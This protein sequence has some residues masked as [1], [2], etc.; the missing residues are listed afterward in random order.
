MKHDRIVLFLVSLLLLS[1]VIYSVRGNTKEGY[2]TF[3]KLDIKWK[4]RVNV[5]GI[6]TKWILVLKYSDG[7]EII[8]VEDSTPKNLKDFNDVSIELLKNTDVDKKIFTGTNKLYV[9][10]NERSE[11]NLAT[12]IDLQFKESDFSVNVTS[13]SNTNTPIGDSIEIPTKFI[14]VDCIGSWSDWGDCSKPC[15]GGFQTRKYTVETEKEGNGKSC[16]EVDGQLDNKMCNTQVCP[17]PPPP[18]APA[19]T[20]QD[21]VGEWVDS[22]CDSFC[23]AGKKQRRYQHVIGQALG[24]NACPYS[25]GYIDPTLYDCTST[26]ACGTSNWNPNY[27]VPDSWFG[28]ECPPGT[29][30][31][32]EKPNDCKG[33]WADWSPCTR[34]C[35][36]GTKQRIYKVIS[37]SY[38]GGKPCSQPMYSTEGEKCNT[39][40]CVARTFPELPSAP[41]SVNCDDPVIGESDA[42]KDVPGKDC[43]GEWVHST[44]C[45][46]QCG[47]GLQTLKYQVNKESLR[48]G[49]CENKGKT[50]EVDCQLRNNCFFQN[51][52]PMTLPPTFNNVSVKSLSCPMQTHMPDS[53]KNTC[54]KVEQLDPDTS[55]KIPMCNQTK[56]I[57]ISEIDGLDLNT[58]NSLY[59]HM[60]TGN[61]T[62]DSYFYEKR[63]KMC[64][65][66]PRIQWT[67]FTLDD[68]LKKCSLQDDCS[69]AD[70]FSE[71]NKDTPNYQQIPGD[72]DPDDDRRSYRTYHGLPENGVS[73]LRNTC[74]LHGENALA[75]N[76]R[77]NDDDP[78]KCK[79]NV[80]TSKT[81]NWDHFIRRKKSDHSSSV[82]SKIVLAEP[83]STSSSSSSSSSSNKQSVEPDIDCVGKWKIPS[84]NAVWNDGDK[85]TSTVQYK[86]TTPKSGNG[87]DCKSNMLTN[88][89]I[90]KWNE[91]IVKDGD[92]AEFLYPRAMNTKEKVMGIVN[93]DTPGYDV[94]YCI[95]EKNTTGFA[96]KVTINGQTQW[97]CNSDTL[98]E[99]EDISSFD[100]LNSLDM[101]E[102]TW[103]F[104]TEPVVLPAPG[105]DCIG[106]WTIASKNDVWPNNQNNLNPHTST[107]TYKITKEKTGYGKDCK[108]YM[109]KNDPVY[110]D[111][112]EVVVKD[113]DKAEFLFKNHGTESTK[114]IKDKEDIMTIINRDAQDYNAKYCI[115]QTGTKG[116]ASQVTVN[117]KTNYICSSYSLPPYLK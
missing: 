88:G 100:R 3:N 92:T 69:G 83:P 29:K 82:L 15:A 91:V 42:C 94:K 113:G 97:I 37:Q 87:K 96:E 66:T 51:L 16:E 62:A 33:C 22:K 21:C 106:K 55:C 9:Y 14:G 78:K 63:K 13:V 77:L 84:S 5:E 74:V 58:D 2:P 80:A 31:D 81:K 6:V 47:P 109:I 72:M 105:T 17:P 11:T 26:E 50:K 67:N 59:K 101:E 73:Q 85:Q 111:W 39:Q 53:S 34:T 102:D 64:G 57:P 52:S 20:K 49:K 115:R 7:S 4:N 93:S 56:K 38:A 75:M 25:H 46:K 10:Y 104:Q 71:Y 36:G 23:G 65:G 30:I 89:L 112:E 68:C 79:D 114:I 76:E 98:G 44:S 95:R 19:A 70:Y 61:T 12:T 117:G 107:V 28:S 99:E 48:D 32:G 18:P 116:T 60:G 103:D 41:N 110:T 35:G 27:Q 24:G 40:P 54:N 1:V 108:S 43:V 90:E 45:S 8:K 86:I